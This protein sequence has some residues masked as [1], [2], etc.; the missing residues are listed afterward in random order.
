MATQR[1]HHWPHYSDLTAGCGNGS[2]TVIPIP[3][4]DAARAV[5]LR[6]KTRG[7]PLYGDIRT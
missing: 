2:G 5:Y 3:G 1:D 7:R 6:K 4:I